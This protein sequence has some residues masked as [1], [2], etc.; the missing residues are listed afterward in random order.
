M[1]IVR[2]LEIAA[3]VE[4]GVCWIAWS[5]AFVKPRK[6]ASGQKKAVRAPSSRW[7][8]LLVMLGY[9]CIWALV[10][11]IGFEKS[12]VSLIASMILGPPAVV[13]VWMAVRHL[14]K[15]WRFEAALS[16]DHK[17]IT[18][19]PYRW[20]RNPIYASMLGMLLQ[21][22]LAKSWWPLIVAGVIFFV[23]GTEIRVRAEERLLEERFGEE[24]AR[25]KAQT[26][27]YLPFLR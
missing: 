20:L 19:G 13:L 14:D 6:R 3:W 26:P 17:L 18:T 25:Y 16:E 15:Q 12:T 10:R 23:F 8:I 11:P 24:F 27:A 1:M 9:A 5:L 7:G 21:T 4:L 2:P 22:G